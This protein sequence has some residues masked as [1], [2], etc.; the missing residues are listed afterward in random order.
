MRGLLLSLWGSLSFA[1]ALREHSEMSQSLYQYGAPGIL[2]HGDAADGMYGLARGR[3]ST[4]IKPSVESLKSEAHHTEAI[5]HRF[6]SSWGS[7]D[8]AS[9][10]Y[11]GAPPSTGPN[12]AHRAP[13]FFLPFSLSLSFFS[14][15]FLHYVSQS[16]GQ[17]LYQSTNM[18]CTT[19]TLHSNLHTTYVPCQ[20]LCMHVSYYACVSVTIHLHAFEAKM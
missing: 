4:R 1:F 13:V 8:G 12:L 14:F 10:A 16:S 6:T 11:G 9:P 20:L 3:I 2:H 7:G 18:H 17:A 19:S 15:F 5:R